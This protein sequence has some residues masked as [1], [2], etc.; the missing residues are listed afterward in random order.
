M[1]YCGGK[2]LK[3]RSQSA[4]SSTNVALLSNIPLLSI[5]LKKHKYWVKINQRL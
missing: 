2:D 3:V 4:A 5:S 1:R